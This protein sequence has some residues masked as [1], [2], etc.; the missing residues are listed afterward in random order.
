MTDKVNVNTQ[1]V[2]D[3]EYKNVYTVKDS[4]NNVVTKE[5][6]ITI[7]DLVKPVI[8]LNGELEETLKLGEKYIEKKAI[9][10]D[11]CDGD[12]SNKLQI[13]GEVDV[14]TI[15]TYTITYSIQDSSGNAETVTRIVNVVE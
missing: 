1:K 3:T 2:S 5:R 10:T 9:V 7:K 4:A 6:I 14:N 13:T 12:I 8:T 11:D 15:G